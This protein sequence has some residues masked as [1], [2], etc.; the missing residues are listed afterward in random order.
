MEAVI[1]VSS[2][3]GKWMG[4]ENFSMQIVSWLDQVDGK[5]EE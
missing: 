4:R 3:K 5:K 2:N 1:K